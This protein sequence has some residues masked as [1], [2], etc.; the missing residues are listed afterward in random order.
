[1]IVVMWLIA[2][3]VVVVLTDRWLRWRRGDAPSDEGTSLAEVELHRIRCLLRLA[4]FKAELRRDAVAARR[5]LD[6]ELN[7]LHRREGGR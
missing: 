1:M 5:S 2:I 4:A 6:A 3:A 7:E